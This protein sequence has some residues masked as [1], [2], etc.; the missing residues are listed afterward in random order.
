MLVLTM[1]AL[2]RMPTKPVHLIVAGEDFV[3]EETTED[4]IAEKLADRMSRPLISLSWEPESELRSY[5]EL[6]T[7]SPTAALAASRRFGSKAANLGFL[8]H[9][10]VL[11]RIG[12][13]GSP[14]AT[15]GYD[16]VPQ[17]FAVPLQYYI[18]FLNHPPNAELRAKLADL[19]N[20]ENGGGLS[21]RERGEKVA[22]V[23]AAFLAAEFPEDALR[24]LRVKLDEVLPGVEKIKVR[25]AQ[26][27]RTCR[28]STEPA[29]TTA[30]LPIPTKMIFPIAAVEL[31]RA[32]RVSR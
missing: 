18:D 2:H 11:G 26:T 28:T 16:L 25:P 8:A 3:L 27:P 24:R 13:V 21:P 32:A 22:Q 14:S 29:C 10:G 30:S 23:Q 20:A 4:V 12:D 31:P 15:K 6:A 9:R 19:I 7:T 1:H 17:G 5:D